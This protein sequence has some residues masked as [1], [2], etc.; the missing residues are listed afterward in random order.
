MQLLSDVLDIWKNKLKIPSGNRFSFEEVENTNV[1]LI[2]NSQNRL[3]IIISKTLPI[4][5]NFKLKYF[6][7]EYHK[8]IQ[9]VANNIIYENCQII[10]LENENISE[11]YL[12]NILFSILD[13]KN[14]R[15]IS[16]NDFIDILKSV[17]SLSQ[18][19]NQRINEIIGAWGELYFFLHILSGAVDL[20]KKNELINSWEGS[21]KRSKIDFRFITCKVGCEIKTSL[22]EERIH[23]ISGHQQCIV[24][25]GL[26]NLYF[27]SIRLK[28]DDTGF[29]CQDLY[30]SIK[31]ELNDNVLIDNFNNKILI[32]GKNICSDS[33]HKFSLVDP[34]LFKIYNSD[35]LI[36][37]NVPLGITDMEWNQNFDLLSDSQY[38]LTIQSI[39]YYF[40]LVL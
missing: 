28:E 11:E 23:H 12:I 25:Q 31:K 36:L 30:S 27:I 8:K 19:E 14:K 5:D 10:I 6:H 24:P 13:F 29:S 35:A 37:P 22:R 1:I 26:E 15:I 18:T 4:P 38:D 3:G 39:K 9:N 32:R 2:K 16:S 7:F 20:D 33:S 40:N 21:E 17:N 34:F